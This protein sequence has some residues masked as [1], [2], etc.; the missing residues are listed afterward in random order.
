MKFRPAIIIFPGIVQGIQERLH[1]LPI[2]FLDV[3]AVGLEARGGVFALGGGGGR[4]ESDR[5]GIV[6][7]NQIIEPEMAG[8]CAGLRGN[9]FLQTTIARQ[10]D[11]VLIEDAVL[12]RVESR[13][14]HFH[15]HRHADGVADALAERAGSAFDARRFKKFRVAPGSC[16]VID[17][18]V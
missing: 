12:A 1:V 13:R 10:T 5:V 6:N 18:S 7:Q 4:I 16:C 11:A 2:D 9:A 14:R 3:E 8:E 17:G 15:R